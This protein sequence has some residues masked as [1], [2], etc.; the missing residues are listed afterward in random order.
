MLKVL[1]KYANDSLK[2]GNPLKAVLHFRGNGGTP[3]KEPDSPE[4][5]QIR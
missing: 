5:E 4:E 2:S 3:L 1:E